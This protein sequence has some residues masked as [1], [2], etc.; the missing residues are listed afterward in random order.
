VRKSRRSAAC[1]LRLQNPVPANILEAFKEKPINLEALFSGGN[2]FEEAGGAQA[3]A[4]TT[5]S[6][7]PK[8]AF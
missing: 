3:S 4:E 6:Q 8:I 7:T 5:T 1:N 2:P